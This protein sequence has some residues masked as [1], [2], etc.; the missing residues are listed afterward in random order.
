MTKSMS[1]CVRERVRARRFANW[2]S[3]RRAPS[4]AKVGEGVRK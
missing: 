2:M 3:S 1:A 4:V